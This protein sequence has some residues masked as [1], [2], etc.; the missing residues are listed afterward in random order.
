MGEY[1]TT[2]LWLVAAVSCLAGAFGGMLGVGGGIILVPVLVGAL[3]VPLPEARSAS[4]ISVIVTS[5]GS[6]LVYLRDDCVHLDKAGPLQLPTILGAIFGAL[7]GTWLDPRIVAVLFACLILYVAWKMM[8][9]NRAKGQATP[10]PNVWP[11]ALLACVGGG[12]LSSL[13]GVGGGLIFVPVMALL[14]GTDQRS[15]SGTS[16]FLIGMTAASSAI[17]YSRSGQLNPLLG[18]FA[19][20]GILAGSQIGARLSRV[21]SEEK[22]RV[23]F[24]LVMVA[25]AVLLLNKVAHGQV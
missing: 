11:W 17:V 19:A 12:M 10:H 15:A 9:Q 18:V 4:L 23:I 6:S 7:L 2:T 25:N 20:G 22:L 1:A 14:F 24:A 16:V 21:I 13:L 5:L 8:M 3:G